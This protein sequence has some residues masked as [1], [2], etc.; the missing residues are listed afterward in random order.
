MPAHLEMVRCRQRA[1]TPTGSLGNGTASIATMSMT[2]VS[3]EK[4]DMILGG[5]LCGRRR[6][7]AR[8]RSRG[9]SSREQNEA[10]LPGTRHA[11]PPGWD[12]ATRLCGAQ[13]LR[14]REHALDGGERADAE[15]LVELDARMEIAQAQIQLLHRV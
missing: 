12:N 13:G 10:D 3:C 14:Q 15:L 11:I 6:R 4:N 8:R 7:G 5:R 9:A 1:P 2:S